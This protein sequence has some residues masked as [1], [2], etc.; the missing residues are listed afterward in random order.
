M[1]IA[2]RVSGILFVI[3]GCQ[4][5]NLSSGEKVDVP[6]EVEE[7]APQLDPDIEVTPLDLD[8]GNIAPGGLDATASDALDE[9]LA[10]FAPTGRSGGGASF[11]GSWYAATSGCSDAAFSPV[12][13][14]N[15]GHATSV[16][17][18][19]VAAPVVI[20]SYDRQC[21]AMTLA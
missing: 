9:P 12:E 19:V 7:E 21:C 8:F 11:D 13:H 5:Y 2:Y 3:A 6:L 1:S 10:P 20:V 14:C 15:S 18:D 16:Q 4:E 17:L